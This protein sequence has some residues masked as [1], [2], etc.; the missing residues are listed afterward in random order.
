M[1][2]NYSKPKNLETGWGGIMLIR[3]LHTC[4]ISSIGVTKPNILNDEVDSL[5]RYK[6]LDGRKNVSIIIM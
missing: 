4:G 2:E 1:D 6:T 5:H 3:G